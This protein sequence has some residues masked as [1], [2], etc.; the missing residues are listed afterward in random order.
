MKEKQIIDAVKAG[1]G[2][3]FGSG[4]RKSGDWSAA[5]HSGIAAYSS[6]ELTLTVKAGTTIHEIEAE[7]GKRGQML[8]F[9]PM[10]HRVILGREGAPTI[11]GALGVDVDGPRRMRVG[12]MR[13]A[14][15]GVRF[16]D[17]QGQIIR[18]G[19]KVMKNVTGL[20]I[21][22]LFA[23]SHGT[24]GVALDVT[25][26]LLPKPKERSVVAYHM[27]MAEAM[28]MMGRLLRIPLEITGATFADGQLFLRQEASVIAPLKKR[29]ENELGFGQL[30]D[31]VDW[32]KLRDWKPMAN[33]S[34]I[35]RVYLRPSQVIAFMEAIDSPHMVLCGGSQIVIAAELAQIE[36]GLT[37]GI[38][39]RCEKGEKQGARFPEMSLIHHE[40]AEKTRSVFDPLNR[41]GRQNEN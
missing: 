5:T 8:G 4:T 19:G 11:G 31:D 27:P 35:W 25:M 20:D 39:A 6:E 40:L 38:F 41:F 13:D 28:N 37:G 18:A 21:T 1:S 36:N 16:V 15:L 3:A 2:R 17:G 24:L 9:E 12:S 26:K 30:V 10:D 33:A 34:E 32:A 23:G 14:L 29:L 7:I 22:R